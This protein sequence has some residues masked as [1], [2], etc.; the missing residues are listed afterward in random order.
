MTK[1]PIFKKAP[2]TEAL[3]DIRVKLPN[4][5]DVTKMDSIYESISEGY[6]EKQAQIETQ[7]DL[8]IKKEE[9]VKTSA[10]K[11][12]GYRYISSDR[13]QIIQAGRDGFTVSRLKPYIRWEEL[14]DEAFRLWKL[15]RD[16]TSPECITRV[17]VRYINNLNIPMPI[18]D[19]TEYLTAPPIVPPE[20]PQ[21]VSSFLTRV[22][23]HESSIGANAIITQA[24]EQIVTDVAPIILDIDVFK[25]QSDG[26]EEEDAWEIIE[27]LR[28]FKNK[29][30]FTSITNK[31]KEMYK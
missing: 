12:T 28:H 6:P 11:V 2:I 30:F 14:R 20:L 4:D 13:K 23:I 8:N 19:F 26:I 27:K 24:L 3:I 10:T 9:S 5:F 1:Y 7:V 18:R 25:F 16:I 15:Y 21:V 29:I 31:L 22:V 17:A